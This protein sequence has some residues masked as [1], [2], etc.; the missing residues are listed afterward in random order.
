MYFLRELASREFVDVLVQ[1]CRL[2]GEGGGPSYSVPAGRHNVGERAREY[3]QL[4]ALLLGRQE[5]LQY[6][7][8]AYEQAAREGVRFPPPPSAVPSTAFVATSAP[9]EWSDSPHCVRCNVPFGLLLRKHHCR[10]CGRTF[11]QDCS[12]KQMAL[13]EMGLYEEVRVCEGCFADRFAERTL[14]RGSQAEEDGQ[15]V[16]GDTFDDDMAKAIALSL[17]ESSSSIIQ[18]PPDKEL[19]PIPPPAAEDYDEEAALAAA[20]AASLRDSQ[21]EMPPRGDGQLPSAAG[22]EAVLLISPIER[23]NVQ[24]F[25]ELVDRLS[26]HD[27]ELEN[28]ELL[29][30]AH[31]LMVLRARLRASIETGEATADIPRVLA[32]LESALQRFDSLTL[33]AGDAG[34]P[35]APDL[36]AVPSQP[37]SQTGSVLYTERRKSPPPPAA[38]PPSPLPAFFRPPPA[39]VVP[40]LQ[41]K[42]V[43]RVPSQEEERLIPDLDADDE[44]DQKPEED[45]LA[46]L[47]NDVSLIQL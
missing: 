21:S 41:P 27:E 44:A 20:I 30:L 25:A 6:M 4:W 28:P 18:H 14:L 22:G 29:Q 46:E 24:L 3:L 34:A 10:R 45:P 19:P 7:R 15:R 23:E 1:L 8:E 31:S 40:V 37:R 17:K 38:S 16:G 12:G 47:L 5:G 39:T 32:V 43:G 9:P 42:P 26:L 35:S 2:E 13:P 36:A 33:P 11:C